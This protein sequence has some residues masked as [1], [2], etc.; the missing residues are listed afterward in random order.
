M[1]KI[2]EICKEEI[3]YEVEDERIK[4]EG[5][6]W[7]SFIECPYCGHY[8]TTIKTQNLDHLLF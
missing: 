6:S 4:R 3:E 5:H 2:C 7:I 8:N 1:L